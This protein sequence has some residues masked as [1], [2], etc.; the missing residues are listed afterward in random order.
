MLILI[1]IEN[2]LQLFSKN[3]MQE[4]T[5]IQLILNNFEYCKAWKQKFIVKSKVPYI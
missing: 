1:L 3:T 2:H 4:T 5:E